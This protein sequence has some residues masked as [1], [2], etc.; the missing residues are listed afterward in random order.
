MRSLVLIIILAL[1]AGCQEPVTPATLPEHSFTI[2]PDR[3]AP[4]DSFVVEF[5]LQNRTPRA[6]TVT[7]GAS[8]LFFLQVTSASEPVSIPGLSYGCLAVVTTFHV[9]PFGSLRVVRHAV[10]DAR[11]GVGAG[12]PLPAGE[13][14]IHTIMLAP[15]PD[16]EATLTVIDP[17]G[18]T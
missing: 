13:Y 17:S 18:A 3:V 1:V 16:Q 12:S 6:L 4:G 11:S 2:T 5:T 14:R 9:P 15:L 7:S 10:A 8:C